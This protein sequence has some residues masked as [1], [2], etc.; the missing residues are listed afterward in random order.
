VNVSGRVAI[1]VAGLAVCAVAAAHAMLDRAAPR[2]G[3]TVK[4]VQGRVDL[5]FTEPL[6]PAFSTIKIVDGKGVQVDR[7]D[8]AVDRAD[9]KHLFVS[10]PALPPGRYR[11]LWRVVSVD[12]HA[13]EG[14]F[15]F[16]VAP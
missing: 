14:D 10:V 13:T 5:W 9:S 3:S 8:P 1:F 2:V 16:E 11:V 7:H 15:T 12:T 6:E 4:A